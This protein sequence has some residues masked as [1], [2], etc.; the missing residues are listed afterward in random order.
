V[1][2]NKRLEKEAAKEKTVLKGLSFCAF[3]ADGN[4][5]EVDIKDGKIIRI[6]PFHYDRKYNPES[7]RPWKIEARGKVFEPCMKSLPGP[8]SL[9]YK[10]RVFSPSRILF[11]LK[12]FDF[13][14]HGERNIQN[15]GKSGYVRISW[16]EALD[17]VVSEIKRIHKTYGP[18]AVF[19]QSDGHGET[20]IVNSAHGCSRKLLTL[21]GG[22]TQQRR[23]PDSWEGWYWGGK[24]VWGCEPVG[25]PP[26][27]NI[28]ADAAKNTDLILYWGCDAETTNWGWAGQ[29]GSR[30]MYWFTDLGIKQVYICPDLNYA[31]AVHADKWIPILP[32]TDAAL[33]LAIAYTWITQ[34]TYDKGYLKTHSIGFDKCK[35]YILGNEDGIPKT[36]QWASELCGIPSRIIKALARDWAVKKTTIAHGNGGGLIRGPYSTEPARLEIL[37]LAMQGLGKPGAHMVK[38]IEWGFFGDFAQMAFPRSEIIPHCMAAYIGVASDFAAKPKQI[39]P[40]SMLPEAILNP[41]ISWYGSTLMTENREDQFKKYTYPVKGCS[42]IH[43]IWSDSPSWV[44]CWNDGNSF[45]KAL[46]DPKIEFFFVQHPWMENDC[47]FADLILPSNTKF[48]EEDI[49]ADS[50][51]GQWQTLLNEEKCIEPIGE[52]KSDYEI[53][54][55]IAEK[56]G[57]LKEYSEDRTIE[58]WKKLGFEH[59]GVE[60]YTNYADFKK[61]GYFVVPTDRKWRDYKAGLGNFCDEPEKYPL[62]TPSGKIELYSQKLAESFPDDEERPPYPKWIPYGKS[63][64]ESCLCERAL[65]YPLLVVSNHPRWGVHSEHQDMTWLREIPTCKI[66]GPDGYLYHPVWIHPIDAVKRGINH[67]D[68]VKLFNERGATLCG[69]MV[70]ERIIP[71]AVS[72]DHGAKYDPIVPGELDRGGANNTLSPNKTTSKNAAGIATSGFLAEI[73]KINLDELRHRYPEAFSRSYKAS[74]GLS[75]DSF[76]YQGK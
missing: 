57:L 45:I 47:I 9:G 14:A 17:I 70:T 35:D 71:G 1:A 11:P 60:K 74:S 13:D 39:I 42:E 64:Q 51:S 54:C 63:H 19:S 69:A 41:P 16:D 65:K 32:N 24:H 36:P 25:I 6:R 30:I 68:I 27:T 5:S 46:H 33:Q 12:R 37:L 23:N 3:A 48:E 26:Q 53:V 62:S 55:L 29:I 58:D 66:K 10:K 22:Y 75:T 67:G 7:F 50:L 8:L 31:A 44:T 59:S 73:K 2:E 28:M 15:R 56:L 43:M 20:K 61:N 38:M 49:A 34:D 52:S 21:L 40:K 4:L 72:S 18:Y 76:L